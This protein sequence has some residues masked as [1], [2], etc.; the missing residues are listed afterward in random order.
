M[1]I[2]GFTRRTSFQAGIVVAQIS[3]FSLI[4]AAIGLRIGHLSKD[5]V[6]IITLVGLIT[7]ALST[8]LIMHS[9]RIYTAVEPYLGWLEIRKKPRRKDRNSKEYELAL[10]GFDRVGKDFIN[11]FK[12]LGKKYVVI[13]FNPSS[14]QDLEDQ[15]IP[16]IY[17]DA[18]DVEF[19]DQLNLQDISLCV[20]TI[21]DLHTNLLITE[22][23]LSVNPKAIVITIGQNAAQAH[24]LYEKGA[25]YVIVP[26]YL[27]ASYATRMI[28]KHEFNRSDYADERE[29][30]LEY[31]MKNYKGATNL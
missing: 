2:L 29:K 12:Q 7:I 10:F 11:A 30:H 21:P 19:L 6:S 13:D 1:N 8:Y 18:D 22:K 23:L 9:E 28:L 15:E 5:V 27:G 16:Y 3:E 17:G 24:Q 4:L 31:L 26:H 14:I 20:S 25:T